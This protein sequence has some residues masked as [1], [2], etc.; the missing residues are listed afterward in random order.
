[1]AMNPMKRRA[2]NSFL[3][4]F[5]LAL[6]IMAVVVM[7]LLSKI[8]GLKQDYQQLLDL[9]KPVYVASEYIQSGTEVQIDSFKSEKVQTSLSPEDMVQA[10]DFEQENEDGSITQKTIVVRTDIPAGTIITKDLLEEVENRTTNDQRMQEY[11]MII[12]P[13]LLKNGDYIDVRLQLPT[14]EEYIVVSKKKVVYTDASTVWMKMYEDEILMLGNAIVEAYTIEGSKL[15]A[16][17]YTQ[18]GMQDAATPTYAPSNNVMNLVDK[19]PNV[20]TE[21]RNAL[22][23]RYNDQEQAAVRTQIDDAKSPYAANQDASVEEGLQEE[24]TK[25]QAGRQEYVEALEGTGTIGTE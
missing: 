24:L 16:A 1:M 4:G 12:L 20:R 14:G 23:K 3:I 5:L 7:L 11:N 9:Q 21:A 15:Y 25:R 19:N 17:P 10:S 13:T 2:Q 22:F 8:Q 18:A 6:V